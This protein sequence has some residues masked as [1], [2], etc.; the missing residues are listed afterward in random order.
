MKSSIK[1]LGQMVRCPNSMVFHQNA[2]TNN[3]VVFHQDGGSEEVLSRQSFHRN[4]TISISVQSSSSSQSSTGLKSNI[5][6]DDAG[7]TSLI[8]PTRRRSN[9]VIE[10]EDDDEETQ[11]AENPSRM[12]PPPN[13]NIL[14]PKSVAGADYE[15]ADNSE[16]ICQEPI[17]GT[18]KKKNGIFWEFFP[19]GRHLGKIPI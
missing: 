17:G 13:V 10:I 5:S 9:A 16:V 8:K 7:S 4:S 18:S 15:V 19:N 2:V 11:P 3:G 14:L 12:L 6:I 1:K